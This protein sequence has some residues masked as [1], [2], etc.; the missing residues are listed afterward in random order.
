VL[1]GTVS[2]MYIKSELQKGEDVALSEDK[3][4]LVLIFM[5][6]P[7][8]FL[9]IVLVLFVL[10]HTVYLPCCGHNG[11]MKDGVVSC[12]KQICC[13]CW[14]ATAPLPAY[15]PQLRAQV[16]VMSEVCDVVVWC[17]VRSVRSKEEPQQREIEAGA[18]AGTL[19]FCKRNKPKREM[20][21][22]SPTPGGGA[23]GP[24]DGLATPATPAAKAGGYAPVG[25]PTPARHKDHPYKSASNVEGAELL[26]LDKGKLSGVVG[27]EV[28]DGAT[29][30]M[31]MDRLMQPRRH[32]LKE[33]G[34]RGHDSCTDDNV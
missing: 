8:T 28:S 6:I 9:T 19:A 17:A 21:M 27:W 34:L 23:A 25:A 3:Q 7:V 13:W 20:Q 4:M 30:K 15:H 24:T 1:I 5:A 14:Y 10:F 26:A 33:P 12:L 11:Y 32:V 29:T 18:R 22:A 2:A 31:C 16:G